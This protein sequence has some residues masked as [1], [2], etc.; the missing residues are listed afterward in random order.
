MTPFQFINQYILFLCFCVLIHIPIIKFIY[1]TDVTPY[2][3]SVLYI[4]DSEK[5]GK[6][7]CLGYKTTNGD[8]YKA[9]IKLNELKEQYRSYN[10]LMKLNGIE[11][12]YSNYNESF[13]KVVDQRILKKS[14]N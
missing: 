1:F 14:E 13:D 4:Y 5:Y 8:F 7:L 11:I 2:R 6:Q 9:E 10:E 12:V 3:A